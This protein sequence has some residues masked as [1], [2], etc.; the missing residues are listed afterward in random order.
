MLVMRFCLIVGRASVPAPG[1]PA[2]AAL[3]A[4][5]SA[6]HHAS[7]TVVGGRGRSTVPA[8]RSTAPYTA[9]LA[10]LKVERV[11]ENVRA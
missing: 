1:S 3:G 2:C 10:K 7:F 4:T 8:P 5:V 9:R 11:D 6:A